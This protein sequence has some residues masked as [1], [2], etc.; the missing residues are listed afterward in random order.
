[1]ATQYST[2][3]PRA[4]GLSDP[5][6][7]PPQQLGIQACTTS[8]GTKLTLSWPQLGQLC[9]R[10]QVNDRSD[11]VKMETVKMETGHME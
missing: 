2:Q 11:T 9:N 10:P 3:Q 5:V 1:M 7:Q 6:A 4:P 8:Y